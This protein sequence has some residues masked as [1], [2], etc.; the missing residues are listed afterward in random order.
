VAREAAKQTQN[1]GPSAPPRFFTLI[2]D[3]PRIDFVKLAKPTMIASLIAVAIGVVSIVMHGGLRYG[4][5]FAGGTMV[6]IRFP[7]ATSVADVRAAVERPEINAAMVQDLSDREFQI[8]L[9][10]E[11]GQDPSIPADAARKGLIEK[12]GEGT[13]DVLRVESVGPK[14]GR[15]L[16]RDALLSVIAATIMMGIYIAFRFDFRFGVGAALALVHD[17]L[18][19]LGAMSLAGMEFDL[20]T[21]AALL[22]VV[23]FSVNDTVIISDRIRENLRAR[24]KEPLEDIINLS[25]NET[26]SRTIITNGTSISVTIVLFLLGGPV[27][28]GFAFAMLVG[29]VAGTYSSIFIASPIVLYL[30]R[31]RH[32]VAAAA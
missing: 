12:F 25:V 3:N 4:I 26:L 7:Q 5:D 11:E 13:F 17:V 28:H 30:E 15:D 22:T 31:R 10:A 24:R 19:T 32:A 1:A 18:I 6:E 9:L 2:P 21:V 8:R 14:V 16:W 20:T 23:G 27:I 29:F